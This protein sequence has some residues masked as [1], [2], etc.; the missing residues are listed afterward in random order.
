MPPLR[1]LRVI[2]RICNR[3]RAGR[4]LVH[5]SAEWCSLA[6]QGAG[7]KRGPVACAT[8]FTMS[9]LRGLLLPTPMHDLRVDPLARSASECRGRN[10]DCAGAKRQTRL[11]ARPRQ[12]DPQAM[13][14]LSGGVF[15]VAVKRALLPSSMAM[16]GNAV[17]R[18]EVM[19]GNR[20]GSSTERHGRDKRA[21]T[22]GSEWR[23]GGGCERI[24]CVPSTACPPL[25]SACPSK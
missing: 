2:A 5:C 19:T 6:K 3:P 8:G 25:P 11:P 9:P 15:W 7:R 4:G 20:A 17:E 22:A 14:A 13:T 10:A 18:L 21:E 1:G 23:R 12:F 24:W 16:C